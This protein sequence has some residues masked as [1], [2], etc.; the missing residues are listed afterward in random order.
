MHVVYLCTSVATLFSPQ[1]FVGMPAAHAELQI[2]SVRSPH[3]W[4][5]S[6]LLSHA[7]LCLQALE[8]QSKTQLRALEAGVAA[9]QR[10]IPATVGGTAVSPEAFEKL[11]STTHAMQ[12]SLEQLQSSSSGGKAGKPHML[13]FV[14]ITH[15]GFGK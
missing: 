8:S 12:R 13:T 5:S 1:R 15:E 4:R 11:A 14:T 9:L 2:S 6:F 7:E 3:V 10:Q